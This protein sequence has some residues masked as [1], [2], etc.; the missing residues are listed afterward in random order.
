[1][2][3]STFKRKCEESLILK[4]SKLISILQIKTSFVFQQSSVCFT[5]KLTELEEK[6]SAPLQYENLT[7]LQLALKL[8]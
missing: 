7:F 4:R 8:S 6:Y 1:M 3:W 5:Q 2:V